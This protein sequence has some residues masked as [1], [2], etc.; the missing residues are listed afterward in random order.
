MSEVSRRVPF[1]DLQAQASAHEKEWR[2]AVDRVVASGRYIGGKEVT[3]FEGD[4]ARYLGCK[5]GIGVGSGSEALVLALTAL[6]IRPGDEVA[7]VSETFI[8]TADAICHVGA[9]PIFVDVSKDSCTMDPERL[10]KVMS[11]R[12]RAILPVHLYGQPVDFSAIKEIAEK[13][14][15]PIVEDAAQ[16]HGAAFDSVKCGG[17]G[18]IA[19]FS[20]YPSKN[21][22]AFGDGGFVS[23][24]DGRLAEQ[25]RL[26]REYGQQQ[27]YVHVLRGFNSRLDALQAAI[28]R[29]K[30]PYLDGWNDRRRRIAREYEEHLSGVAN[31]TLPKETPRRHHIYHI[32]AV[33]VRQRDRLA[34]FLKSHGVET[35]IHYPIPVHKQ[36]AYRDVNSADGDLR[37]SDLVS[38]TELSLPMYPEMSS[39]DVEFVSGLVEKW[40]GEHGG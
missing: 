16:A 29:A 19:C 7:T 12:V 24:N 38:E 27:K 31:L 34:E 32:Y 23:T 2:A 21:L 17:L 3:E 18:T 26:L 5:F 25:I 37:E 39:S 36:E 33:R 8:S 20:F 11:P 1:V 22:G 4:F 14:N 30:L 15:V 6:G 9:T 28:L 40:C 13:W 35:G 10:A